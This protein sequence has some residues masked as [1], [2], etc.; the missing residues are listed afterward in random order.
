MPELHLPNEIRKGNNN[1]P[2]RIKLLLGWVL[3]GGEK[4][5]KYS[6]NSN[7]ICVWESNI[8]DSLRQFCL[9]E[10]YGTSKENP[11][12]LLPKTEQIAIE[13]WNKNACKEK[14]GHY[15][16]GILWKSKNTKSPYNRQIADS[17]LKSLENKFKKEPEFFQNYQQTIE[18]YLKNGYVT[19]LYTKL[20]NENKEIV[21]YTPQS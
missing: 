8:N 14:S 3:L 6:L 17:R 7:R 2:I 16:I 18:S 20:Y 5:E 10:S 13:I 21:N 12:A 9:T 15:S 4:K 1:E 19:K 11:E